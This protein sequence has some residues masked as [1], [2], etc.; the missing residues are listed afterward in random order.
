MA[1]RKITITLPE[2]QVEQI[3]NSA[4][5]HGTVAWYIKRA[6]AAALE[7]E[8]LFNERL[9]ETLMKT[10][11]PI[12]PKEEAWLDAMA[13]SGGRRKTSRKRTAA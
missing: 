11:G 8:R 9:N 1:T 13:T 3:R 4:G 2:E 7:D 5:P 12:T 6:I 10:G